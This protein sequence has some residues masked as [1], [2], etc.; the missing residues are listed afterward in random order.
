MQVQSPLNAVVSFSGEKQKV[1]CNKYS[2]LKKNNNENCIIQYRQKQN[3]INCP[4]FDLLSEKFK[5]A[6]N[7]SVVFKIFCY[8]CA[9]K[10]HSAGEK[11]VR[12]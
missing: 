8:F 4:R 10:Q 9:E 12:L 2:S 11:S 6:P 1:A 5:L 3:K 7:D